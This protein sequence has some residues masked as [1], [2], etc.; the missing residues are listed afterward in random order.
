MCE[1]FFFSPGVRCYS[2]ACFIILYF[3]FSLPSFLLLSLRTLGSLL[4]KL[5]CLGA[6]VGVHGEFCCLILAYVY[7]ALGNWLFFFAAGR[8]T[9]DWT[10]GWEGGL[11]L[12]HFL[13]SSVIYGFVRKGA[14][15]LAK[16]FLSSFWV[17]NCV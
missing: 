2:S 5:F 16:G 17:A 14:P 1:T 15:G 13:L 12:L 4:S 7:G 8:E 3:F 9:L 11:L 10:T 6:W